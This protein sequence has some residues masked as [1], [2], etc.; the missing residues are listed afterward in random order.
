MIRISM[1]RKK[2]RDLF[3]DFDPKF[4]IFKDRRTRH[5]YAGEEI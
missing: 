5:S 4:N 3:N 2:A 1:G